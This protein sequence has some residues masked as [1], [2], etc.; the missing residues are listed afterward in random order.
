MLFV[1]L[2]LILGLVI[3]H[4]WIVGIIALKWLFSPKRDQVYII[5]VICCRVT[6]C[7]KRLSCRCSLLQMQIVDNKCRTI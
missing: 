7:S 6:Y 4:P 1:V 2:G 5:N 3:R